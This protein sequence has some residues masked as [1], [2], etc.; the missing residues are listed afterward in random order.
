VRKLK[1]NSKQLLFFT[2]ET[3]K[4][5][6]KIIFWNFYV[7]VGPHKDIIISNFMCRY[8]GIEYIDIIYFEMRGGGM[9]KNVV[10]ITSRAFKIKNLIRI[11]KLFM[12]SKNIHF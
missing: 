5:G 6:Q 1:K 3:Q 12:Q 7:F 11:Q 4:I 10:Q 9:G 2:F 8:T